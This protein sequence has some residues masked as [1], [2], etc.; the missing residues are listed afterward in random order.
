MNFKLLCLSANIFFASSVFACSVVSNDYLESVRTVMANSI[1]SDVYPHLTDE[2]QS[3]FIKV[4][5]IKKAAIEFCQQS[6]RLNDIIQ[7]MV[8]GAL[9]IIFSGNDPEQ[10]VNQVMNYLSNCDPLYSSQYQ[11]MNQAF[12]DS[13][14]NDPDQVAIF[15][16]IAEKYLAI[17]YELYPMDDDIRVYSNVFNDLLGEI[18]EII[19][20]GTIIFE[21]IESAIKY[22][23]DEL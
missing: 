8:T 12:I 1:K 21:M 5:L 20:E 6:E 22:H 14:V 11:Y 4:F 15:T 13:F 3:R 2:E 18:I 17:Y 23:I 10:A 19:F 9:N 16:A 7:P